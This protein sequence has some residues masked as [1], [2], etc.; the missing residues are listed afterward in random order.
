MYF[1]ILGKHPQISLAE[2]QRVHPSFYPSTKKG[3]VLFDT[4]TPEL[5]AKL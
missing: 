4:E 1:A 2:L 5:L 3:I